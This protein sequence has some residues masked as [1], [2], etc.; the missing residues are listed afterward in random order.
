M[1]GK[2]NA[3]RL[4]QGHDVRHPDFVDGC[5]RCDQREADRQAVI[6]TP[7]D[8]PESPGVALVRKLKS[9]LEQQPEWV[10]LMAGPR[11]TRRA[12][13]EEVARMLLMLPSGEQGP[14]RSKMRKAGRE[15]RKQLISPRVTKLKARRAR[16]VAQQEASRRR[17]DRLSMN[18]LVDLALREDQERE[19]ARAAEEVGE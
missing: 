8:E 11:K 14:G 3:E 2:A 6:W 10:A 5:K 19:A 17:Y 9:W 4:A 16:L 12:A 7:S 18:R 1:S 13:A 15:V